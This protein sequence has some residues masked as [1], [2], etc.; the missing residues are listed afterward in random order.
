MKKNL[1]KRK[2]DGLYTY[3]T[4]LGVL[5]EDYKISLGDFS[6]KT[7]LGDFFKSIGEDSLARI[8]KNL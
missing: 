2:D 5:A 4:E 8:L 6:P 1:I 3:D 7:K